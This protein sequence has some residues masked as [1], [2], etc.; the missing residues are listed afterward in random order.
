[1]WLKSKSGGR[2]RGPASSETLIKPES[3]TKRPR[4][5]QRASPGACHEPITQTLGGGSHSF[6]VL[7]AETGVPGVCPCYKELST[8]NTEGSLGPSPSVEEESKFQGYG[9]QSWIIF[10]CYPR[11]GISEGGAQA[12][13]DYGR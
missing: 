9:E 1:M 6:L 13:G 12:Q 3:L 11:R 5:V 2:T 10:R 4:G 8:S 7:G